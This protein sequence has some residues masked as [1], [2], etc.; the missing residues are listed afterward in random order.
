MKAIKSVTVFGRNLTYSD[1]FLQFCVHTDKQK[2][3][4]HLTQ[5]IHRQPQKAKVMYELVKCIAMG[6]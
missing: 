2:T 5:E 3:L 1:F 4:Q 6:E